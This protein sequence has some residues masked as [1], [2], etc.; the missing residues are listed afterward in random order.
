MFVSVQASKVEE[1]VSK[2]QREIEKAEEERR[3]ASAPPVYRSA[4][5]SSLMSTSCYEESSG[6]ATDTACTA[7]QK[8]PKFHRSMGNLFVQQPVSTG[9]INNHQA[10]PAKPAFSGKE[11]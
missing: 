3:K 8:Q 2:F 1:M 7:K 6:F 11:V 4:S 9:R 5:R 10:P